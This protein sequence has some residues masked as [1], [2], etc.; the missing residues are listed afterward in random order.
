[1]VLGSAVAGAIALLIA[2]RPLEEAKP[3]T[4]A[5]SL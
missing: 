2:K 4:A 3:S 1:M 5:P